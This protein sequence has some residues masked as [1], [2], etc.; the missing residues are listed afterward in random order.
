M[1]TKIHFNWSDDIKI[2][3]EQRKQIREKIKKL[4]EEQAYA[5]QTSIDGLGAVQ[6]QRSDGNIYEILLCLE[7]IEVLEE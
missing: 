4:I 2:T 1:K 7:D 3:R 6:I 5:M